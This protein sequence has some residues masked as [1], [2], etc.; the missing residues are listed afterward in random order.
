[1]D[2]RV[3]EFIEKHIDLIEAGDF[4]T[5]YR[6]TTPGTCFGE[7]TKEL[8]SAGID[9]LENSN[10]VYTKMFDGS[11]RSGEFVVPEGIETLE[12]GAFC[13]SLFSSVSLPKSLVIIGVRCFLRADIKKVVFS[14]DC[15]LELVE[16]EAFYKAE[17]LTKIILPKRCKY[18]KIM[19]FAG[20][21]LQEILLPDNLETIGSGAFM[22]TPLRNIRIPKNIS[23][24]GSNVFSGCDNLQNI[25]VPENVIKRKAFWAKAK[26][27]FL[28]GNNA[29]IVV[30]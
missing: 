17:N 23:F 27:D 16:G 15:N 2:I 29:E 24:V 30:V 14:Y 8:M 9:P 21:G 7:I 12:E 4:K 18:I 10:I 3:K 19:A 25:Y 22:G 26:I 11:T 1:M 6:K 20:S 28:E 13:D 5:L